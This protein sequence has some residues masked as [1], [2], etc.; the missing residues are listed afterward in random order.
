MKFCRF[1]ALIY[2]VPYLS[3]NFLNQLSFFKRKAQGARLAV[4]GL[5]PTGCGILSLGSFF[6]I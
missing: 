5:K 2:K 3:G 4:Y 1:L 6:E